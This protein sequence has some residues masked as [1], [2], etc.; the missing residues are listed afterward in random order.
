MTL[1]CKGRERE[2]RPLLIQVLRK[3]LKAYGICC[4]K[5]ILFA[6]ALS[7]TLAHAFV[8]LTK[9]PNLVW[10]YGIV[11]LLAFFGVGFWFTYRKLDAKEGALNELLKAISRWEW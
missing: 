7:S 8:P 2:S 10:N 1:R 5:F 3:N 11:S 4:I 9:D 6:S